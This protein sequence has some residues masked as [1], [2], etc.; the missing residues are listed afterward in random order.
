MADIGQETF[1]ALTFGVPSILSRKK[2]KKKEE[3]EK[4]QQAQA[5]QAAL[6]PAA[7]GIGAASIGGLGLLLN[8]LAIRQGLIGGQGVATRFGASR[9]LL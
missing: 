2:K 6:V 4:K 7:T 1:R 3:E 8:E 5:L 9:G